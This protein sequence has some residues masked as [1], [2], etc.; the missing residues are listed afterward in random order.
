MYLY[1]P[2]THT[3]FSLHEVGGINGLRT[4]YESLDSAKSDNL[5][6]FR[7]VTDEDWP[8]PGIMFGI[9]CNS[10]YYWCGQHLIVQRILCA[11]NPLH[12][13]MGCLTTSCLK[14]LP[15]FIMVIPGMC[16]VAIF[17]ESFSNGTAHEYDRAYP[18][19]V[20]NTLPVGLAGIM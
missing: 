13:K 3:L 17:P 20:I 9:L 4:Y 6:M 19:L 11:K 15:V 14:L 1:I 10:Y 18:L 7:S 16:A 8:W 5:H 12:A 2:N